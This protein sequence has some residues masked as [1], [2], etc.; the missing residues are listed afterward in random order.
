MEQNTTTTHSSQRSTK[1]ITDSELD[2]ILAAAVVL[3]ENAA[4]ECTRHSAFAPPPFDSFEEWYAFDATLER[5]LA[6]H[7]ARRIRSAA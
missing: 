2:R 4:Q 6:S 5:W 3:A 7:K 1:I